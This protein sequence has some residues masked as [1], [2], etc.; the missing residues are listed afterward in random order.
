MA[1]LVLICYKDDRMRDNFREEAE[2]L[3]QR[4]TPDNIRHVSPLTIVRDGI[5]IA[6][7][8]ETTATPIEET[9]V[10]MG[11]LHRPDKNWFRPLAN[12]PEG[13]FALFRAN[14]RFIELAT[15]VVG[16]RAVW[17][18]QTP[19]MFIAA[20][21]QRAIVYFLQSFEPNEQAF[22]WMLSAG[23]LGPGLSWDRRARFL[24]PHSRLLLDRF[25]WSLS[26]N[27]P[28]TIFE[29]APL[30]KREQGRQL[31]EAIE[32]VLQEVHFDPGQWVL[33]LS[34]GYDSRLLLLRLKDRFPALK[35]VTWGRQGALSQKWNDARIARDLCRV[36]D[37]THEY[38]VT[39]ISVEPIEKLFGRFLALGEGRIDHLEAYLDGFYVW[40]HLSEKGVK[41]IIRGDECFGSRCLYSELD[42]RKFVFATMIP[43]YEEFREMKL[44]ASFDQVWP[45]SMRVRR[46]E[47]L[48]TWR[49]RLYCEY[50]F[51]YALSALNDLKLSY[52]EIINPFI[53]RRI[54]DRV[55]KMP[56][57][58]RTEKAVFRQIV[59]RRSPKVPFSRYPAIDLQ[60]NYLKAKAVRE[61]LSDH[62]FSAHCRTV[63]P[64]TLI[65]K[66]ME[67]LNNN[68]SGGISQRF[69]IIRT[70]R[71]LLPPRMIKMIKKSLSLK[72]RIDYFD[73]GLRC[74]IVGNM[75]ALLS[76]DARALSGVCKREM[77]RIKQSILG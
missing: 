70:L 33:P 61:F 62:L 77:R 30:S 72:E 66:T 49:D 23:T 45:E 28:L 4:L 65:S 54:V 11:Y 32:D 19:E 50:Y 15:D 10:A 36:L 37:V 38:F 12:I 27:A 64:H 21:S 7:F 48:E 6:V 46:H 35:C 1:K 57:S 71:P 25:S 22:A 29:A 51:P 34:G 3:S 42:F 75:T 73:L 16:S 9:G 40:K 69:P 2:H 56:D 44:P 20:T 31:E 52:V 5:H 60:R 55:R 41:G 53:F 13:S 17:Y 26:L 8:G 76:R 63:L 59:K 58:L 39:E 14:R 74:C 18:A 67:N 68:H 47:T 24:P 43:D